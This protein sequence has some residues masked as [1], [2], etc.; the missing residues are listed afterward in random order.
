MIR[1][2]IKAHGESCLLCKSCRPGWF[3]HLAP[4]ALAEFDELGLQILLP[5]ATCLFLEGD[6]AHSVFVLCSGRVKLTKTSRDGKTLLLRIANEGD[7]LGLSAAISSTPYEVSAIA[8]DDAQVKSFAR[9]A[10][11][12]FIERHVEGNR[13]AATVLNQEYRAALGAACR[14]ALSNS[15]AARMACALLE[16]ASEQGTLGDLQPQLDM[17]L[18]HEEFA[19]VLGSSRESV[20]RAL[21]D[22]KRKGL[23]RVEKRKFTLLRRNALELLI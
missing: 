8:L 22:F 19:T 17:P 9:R 2:P 10:F 12:R 15:V 16:F 20:T 1:Q 6:T 14:L 11:L 21:N 13:H 18:T 23:V 3:C 4:E 7:V 5:A